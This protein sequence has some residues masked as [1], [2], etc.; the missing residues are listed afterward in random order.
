MPDTF[1]VV[2]LMQRPVIHLLQR[3]VIRQAKVRTQ[4][5]TYKIR[6]LGGSQIYTH[7]IFQ[8]YVDGSSVSYKLGLKSF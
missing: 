3:P 2:R 6:R 4:S 5:P 1:L 7:A 8:I